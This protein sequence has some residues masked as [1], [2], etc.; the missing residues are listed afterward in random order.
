VVEMGRQWSE[1]AKTAKEAEWRPWTGF[2]DGRMS[3]SMVK[4]KARPGVDRGFQG[5]PLS[6]SLE[7]V[8]SFEQAASLD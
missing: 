7:A 2:V 8:L 1:G 5:E 3:R 6:A 4:L